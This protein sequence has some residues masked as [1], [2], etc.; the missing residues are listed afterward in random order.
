ML[1]TAEARPAGLRGAHLYFL[2]E[3]TTGPVV[4]GVG[5]ERSLLQPAA[6]DASVILRSPAPRSA[7]LSSLT[8]QH[9]A[10]E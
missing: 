10:I 3:D 1:S 4:A 5:A 6:D 8:E 9:T 7:H 2:A